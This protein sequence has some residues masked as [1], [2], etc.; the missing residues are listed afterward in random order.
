MIL[1][2]GERSNGDKAISEFRIGTWARG[3]QP[4]SAFWGA[5]RGAEEAL[6]HACRLQVA[7]GP[8]VRAR[9]QVP[10]REAGFVAGIERTRGAARF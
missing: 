3:R 7:A 4:G 5:D 8:L 6:G 2:L 1:E 9:G 10:G